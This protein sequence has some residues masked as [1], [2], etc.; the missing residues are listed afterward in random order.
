M[1]LEHLQANA[2]FA[3]FM[4]SSKANNVALRAD[5]GPIL[6]RRFAARA[7]AWDRELPP[8][9]TPWTDDIPQKPLPCPGIVTAVDQLLPY[10]LA[11][12]TRPSLH[13]LAREPEIKKADEVP[14]QVE[15]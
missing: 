7:E 5:M 2:Y 9:G 1:T 15:D 13:A 11:F 10:L 8:S 3:K 4:E 12:E 14:G 6:A